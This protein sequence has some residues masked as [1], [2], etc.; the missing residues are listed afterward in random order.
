MNHNTHAASDQSEP[1]RPLRA[2]FTAYTMHHAATAKRRVTNKQQFRT[3]LKEPFSMKSLTFFRTAPGAVLA[4]AIFATTG[5]GAYALTNWFNADVTVKQ[6]NT[7][8]SV[9]LADCK[10]TLPPGIESGEDKHDIR[11]KILG[12]PHISAADL[13]QRL[14]AECE[15]QVVV[16]FYHNK[17]TN[18]HLQVGKITSIGNDKIALT[19]PWGGKTN[20]KT[21]SLTASSTIYDQASPITFRDL[22]IGDNIVFVTHGQAAQEGVDPLAAANDV[23]SIFRTQ[24]D[25]AQAMSASKNGFYENNNIMPLDMYNQLHK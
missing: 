5:A 16:D 19:Y 25:P 14:L 2:D 12:N 13:Q 23:L 20:E 21:F 22:R 10:G 15:Y 11:F 18:A 4:V 3:F 6:N 9:N 1:R 24:Y 8:L 17:L 7:V